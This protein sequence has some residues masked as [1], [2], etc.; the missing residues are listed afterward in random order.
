MP[1][2]L[3]FGAAIGDAVSAG[4][5]G[6]SK[7]RDRQF[8]DRKLEQELTVQRLQEEVRLMIA[9]LQ[10]G[11]RNSRH[12]ETMSAREREE[13]GRTTRH[14][15][16]MGVRRGE[17]E[18]RN[19]RNANDRISREW[20]SG[21]DRG[22]R[23]T[24]SKR[25]YD[26][27]IFSTNTASRDR[28][29]AL[30]QAWDLGVMGNLTQRRGQD[31]S[32]AN[33]RLRSSD[34]FEGVFT[35]EGMSA[36]AAPGVDVDPWDESQ[37]AMPERPVRRGGPASGGVPTSSPRPARSTPAATNVQATLDALTALGMSPVGMG[38]RPSP[39]KAGKSVTRAQLEAV[40]KRNGSTVDQERRRAEAE[41]YVVR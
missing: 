19:D 41:G 6:Y 14:N 31:T 34:P 1:D 16:T 28:G 39:A 15:E 36:D 18:G 24:A 32:R 25:S 27:S 22:Q 7:E 35:G 4:F 33:A 37:Y 8:A 5:G 3:D 2:G 21:L 26:A 30:D 9:S 13:E 29:N 10:E 20:T 23:E 40:A 12:G 17:E 11:G 38:G